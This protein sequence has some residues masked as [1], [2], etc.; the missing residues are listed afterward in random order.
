MQVFEV[1]ILNGGF[2]VAKFQKERAFM[3]QFAVVENI[4]QDKFYV[5]KEVSN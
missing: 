2:C 3:Y 1:N 4:L 5:K